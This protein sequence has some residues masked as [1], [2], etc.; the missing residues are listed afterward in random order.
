MH[1][2]DVMIVLSIACVMGF[3]PAIYVK[4]DLLL[5]TGYFFAS[6]I[7]SFAGGHIAIWYF[8]HTDKAGIIFGAIFGAL[9]LVV[10]WHYSR[11]YARRSKP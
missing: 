5:A 3:T 11:K 6:T 10:G 1:P 9:V 7:G 2:A 8:P 4:K